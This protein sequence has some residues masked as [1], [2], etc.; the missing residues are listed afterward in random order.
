MPIHLPYEGEPIPAGY[1]VTTRAPRLPLALGAGLLLGAWAGSMVGATMATA[2]QR[3]VQ[4]SHG[5][6]PLFIPLAGPFI[7]LNTVDPTGASQLW[8][9]LDG[10]TQVAG[11]TLMLAAASSEEER[12]VL[13]DPTPHQM[14]GMA[15]PN[16]RYMWPRVTRYDPTLP[17]PPGYHLE[18]RP[19]SGLIAT[20]VALFGGTYLTSAFVGASALA[21]DTDVDELGL[22]LVPVIGPLLAV[23]TGEPEGAPAAVLVVDS[24]A[25]A[26][27]GALLVA[28][29][30]ARKEKLVRDDVR[31]EP[32]LRG[33]EI[34]VGPGHVSLRVP[35]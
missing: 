3:D 15:S 30:F 19:V 2:M 33:A 8:L 29:I 5:A 7:S 22:L 16:A 12:L 31:T 20:G 26:T 6:L 4:E 35:F 17:I 34:D 9:W 27:G 11:L 32:L 10:F 21:E 18:Q 24:L 25:Q 28:S 23:E 1:Q 13:R 14:G